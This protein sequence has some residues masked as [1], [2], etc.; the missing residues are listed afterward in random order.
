MARQFVF[1]LLILCGVLF[2]GICLAQPVLNGAGATFPSPLYRKWIDVYRQYSD[3]RIDYRETGSGKGIQLFLEHQ[4]DFGAT[5]IFLT[6]E[7]LHR[8][9]SEIIHIPTCMGAVVV[10][11]NLPHLS[12][13]RLT[14]DMLVAIFMGH[15]TRWSDERLVRENPGLFQVDMDITVVHRSD[16][17]GTTF[18]FSDYLSKA[19]QL[20]NRQM[21]R[22]NLLKWPVGI[23]LEGNP[24][25]TQY[26]KKIP[27]SIS[28]VSLNYAIENKLPAALVQNRS[29]NFIRPSLQSVSSAAE[30]EIPKDMRVLLTDTA[31]T[32]GYP[33]SALTYLI[34]YKEQGYLNRSWETAVSLFGFLQ[35]ITTKGQDYAESMSYAR[36]PASTASS[37][38]NALRSMT[39]KG[40]IIWNAP[41]K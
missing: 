15:I 13:I 33:I 6:D 3:A 40:D 25:V 8:C 4:L 11:F 12:D 19:D 22:G 34:V 37:I 24:G 14:A 1:C 7:E 16:S 23:G 18:I 21:G 30:V 17:S 39:F 29:G 5:D 31:A 28:Y 10:V 36:L 41:K 38:E 20:W 2:S 9:P 26:V 32:D 27:G 35:W